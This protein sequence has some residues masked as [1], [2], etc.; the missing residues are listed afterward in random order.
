MRDAGLVTPDPAAELIRQT[1]AE[2]VTDG[3]PARSPEPVAITGAPGVLRSRLAVEEVAVASV[4]S[5]MVAASAL[6]R[7]RGGAFGKPDLDRS[8]VA[9][10][11]R[12]ERYFRRAGRPASA[13]FASL[14][15]FWRTADGW[16]RTHANYPWHRSAPL[17]AL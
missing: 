4:A 9:A 8:H 14:S 3:P 12:S 16:V 1:W 2:L 13:G 15:R 17:A 10:A 11:V 7:Q 5:A 6:Y